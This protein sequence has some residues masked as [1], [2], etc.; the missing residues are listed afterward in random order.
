[1]LARNRQKYQSVEEF[2]EEEVPPPIIHDRPPEY[3]L[4]L[5]EKD[6]PVFWGCP[7]ESARRDTNFRAGQIYNVT[8]DLR[9]SYGTNLTSLILKENS[10]VNG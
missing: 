8:D 10:Y 7:Q 5:D 4:T 6:K 1:M 9:G 3:R 2:E